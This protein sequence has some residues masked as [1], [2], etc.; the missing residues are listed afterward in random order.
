LDDFGEYLVRTGRL[1]EAEQIW[2]EAHKLSVAG[3]RQSWDLKA[4]AQRLNGL[5]LKLGKPQ[6]AK[7]WADEVARISVVDGR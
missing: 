3:A 2:L 5:Y 6:E 7:K 1:E 4:S